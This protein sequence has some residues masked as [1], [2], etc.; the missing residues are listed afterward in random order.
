MRSKV[1]LIFLFVILLSGGISFAEEIF[2]DRPDSLDYR[3]ITIENF[4]DG[5]IILESYPVE[6]HD[7]DSWELNST[8]TYQNSP[9]S[10]KLFGNTWK[11][12]NIEPVAV[13]SGDVWQ[14]A[15]YISSQAE[16]QGF[17]IMDTANVLFYSFAKRLLF[18]A[19]KIGT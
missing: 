8:I 17:G 3:A 13:D 15:A 5:E 14:I 6:D 10:L 4:D 7:P 12:E 11:V 2:P 19:G 9:W 16:I 1:M 18:F